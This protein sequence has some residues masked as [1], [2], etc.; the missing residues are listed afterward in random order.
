MYIL[1]VLTKE[2]TGERLVF[3][4]LVTKAGKVVIPHLLFVHALSGCDTVSATFG[5]GK[6]RLKRLLGTK[7]DITVKNE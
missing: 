3:S 2:I 5:Q 1:S 6:T 4:D 7:T